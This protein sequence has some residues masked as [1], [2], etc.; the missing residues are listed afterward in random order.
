MVRAKF[1]QAQL[2]Q[3][4]DG[5]WL[6]VKPFWEDLPLLRRW[7]H[8]GWKGVQ[9]LTLGEYRKR[10][11]LDAN[12]YAWVLLDKLSQALN[13]PKEEV[14]REE[15][16]KTPGVSEMIVLRKE[17]I[18]QFRRSWEDGHL[19]QMVEDLGPHATAKGYHTLVCYYG[20][21]GYDTAQMTR[22]IEN[23]VQDC[24][25]VG[26]ETATDQEISLLLEGWDRAQKNKGP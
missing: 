15:I 21:S 17:A 13:L 24:K 3:R 7:L 25:T 18:P 22:L 1:Q 14:Y 12:G 9:Q 4:E 23:I 20:S 2:L 8:V 11:S 5:F 6:A 16:R 19:G 26:I 10:R